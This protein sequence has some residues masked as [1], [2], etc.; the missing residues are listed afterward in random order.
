[1]IFT[2]LCSLIIGVCAAYINATSFNRNYSSDQYLKSTPQK[3]AMFIIISIGVVYLF[4][5][6]SILLPA[7]LSLLLMKFDF[8]LYSLVEIFA[9]VFS[10]VIFYLIFKKVLSIIFNAKISKTIKKLKQTPLWENLLSTLNKYPQSP[11][12][13]CADGIAIK[14]YP[15]NSIDYFNCSETISLGKVKEIEAEPSICRNEE[16]YFTYVNCFNDTCEVIKFSKY[17]LTDL[18]SNEIIL[19]GEVIVKLYKP[20]K[21]ISC[22]VTKTY[23]IEKYKYDDNGSDG[24]IYKYGSIYTYNP[25]TAGTSHYQTKTIYSAVKYVVVYPQSPKI[26]KK[27][28]KIKKSR[29]NNWL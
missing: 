4:Y 5:I 25:P 7:L 13:V 22:A 23:T 16:V 26:K 2:I 17:G 18:V 20:Y 19:L 11:I 21:Y 27:K 14:K 29:K 10:L 24:H 8:I 9:F 6:G 12:Y 15:D 1:M 3:I 28:I